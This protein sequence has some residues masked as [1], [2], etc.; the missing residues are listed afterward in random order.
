MLLARNLITEEL[1]II[2]LAHMLV[3]DF[4]MSDRLKQGPAAAFAINEAL[5]HS[6]MC[7]ICLVY[8]LNLETVQSL[9]SSSD[10]TLALAYYAAAHWKT[11]FWAGQNL[12]APSNATQKL[13]KSC[14]YRKQKRSGTG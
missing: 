1:G 8:L 13:L 7:Q 14:S 11:H 10:I 3:N 9:T 2:M 12:D 6:W 4:L 5:A